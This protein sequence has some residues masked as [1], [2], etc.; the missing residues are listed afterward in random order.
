M[1][2]A[3]QPAGLTMCG[4]SGVCNACVRVEHFCHIDIGFLDELSKLRNL[5]HLLEGEDLI[6]LVSIDCQTCRIVA[7]VFEP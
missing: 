3:V 6:L 4:P 1:R 2:M 7:A 5:A